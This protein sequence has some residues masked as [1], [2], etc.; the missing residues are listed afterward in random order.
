[1]WVI[2]QLRDRDETPLFKED[3]YQ[4]GLIFDGYTTKKEAL[5]EVKNW[6]Y[7]QKLSIG[8]GLEDKKYR[9]VVVREEEI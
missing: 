7:I 3:D 6:K 9:W 1:M 5:A 8:F 2:I 4:D